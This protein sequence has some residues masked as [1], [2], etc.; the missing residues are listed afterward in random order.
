MIRTS[1]IANALGQRLMTLDPALPVAWP[2]KDL[3]AGTAHPY[4]VFDLVP[5]SR[6][7]DTTTADAPI[8]RGF[9]QIA[10]MTK[11]N[12]FASQGMNIAEDVAA[13]FPN[14]RKE[15]ITGGTLETGQAKVE[16]DGYPDGPH[17]RTPVRIPYMAY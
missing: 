10:V 5:V 4:L 9:V 17:W 7:D 15:A 8:T 13:L 16:D 3:P 14:G 6:T 11:I 1:A 2:N 12:S